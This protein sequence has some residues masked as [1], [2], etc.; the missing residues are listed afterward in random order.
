LNEPL[1]GNDPAEPD[2]VGAT[3]AR[4]RKPLPGCK[5]R[6]E[7]PLYYYEQISVKYFAR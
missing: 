3:A 1:A 6:L 7:D 4:Q 5:S 2:T